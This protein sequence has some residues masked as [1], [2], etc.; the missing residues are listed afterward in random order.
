VRSPL[1]PWAVLLL[2]ALGACSQEA[3]PADPKLWTLFDVQALYQ[4]G[5]AA[6]HGLAPNDGLPGGVPLGQVL[7]GSELVATHAWTDVGDVSYVTTEVWSDFDRVWMQPAYVPITGW[8][9]GVPQPLDAGQEHPIFSVGPH[10]GFYCPFWQIVYAQVPA[11]TAPTAL[12]SAR[13]ILDGGYPLTPSEGRTMPLAPAGITGGGNL[14]TGWLDG[15]PIAYLD[16]GTATFTWDAQNVVQALPLYTFTV[17]GADGQPHVLSEMPNVLGTAPPAGLTVAPTS[18]PTI[19]TQTAP[20]RY[21]AYWRIYTVVV[22]SFASIYAP[23]GTA[24]AADLARVRGT[25][26]AQYTTDL[27][28]ED[29]SMLSTYI[30]RVSI[31]PLDPATGVPDCFA[32]IMTLNNCTWVTSQAAL[33]QDLDLSTGGATGI[34]VTAPVTNAYLG[35]VTPL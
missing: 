8:Q 6:T 12:T 28:T 7:N 34:T 19:G 23:M 5:A 9:G 27:M 11:G 20:P 33:E 3:T 16:F 32:S 13:Q 29:P 18:A 25:A 15:A 30:G 4:G 31:D 2:P 35:P 22:P 17:T 14:G 21:S 24:L 1:R 26:P 10:S